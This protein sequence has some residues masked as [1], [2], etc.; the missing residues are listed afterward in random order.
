MF[1]LIVR[2][3]QEELS[4]VRE[5]ELMQEQHQQSLQHHHQH[6]Q[7]QQSNPQVSVKENLLMACVTKIVMWKDLN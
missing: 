1:L 7:Q 5:E 6:Q 3:R 2:L 4:Q